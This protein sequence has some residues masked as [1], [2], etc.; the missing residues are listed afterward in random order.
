[1]HLVQGGASGYDD[2]GQRTCRQ[3]A[4]VGYSG[5]THR[6]LDGFYQ[7]GR[8]FIGGEYPECVACLK[9][10]RVLSGHSQRRLLPRHQAA[11]R[12][13]AIRRGHCLD[14]GRRDLRPRKLQSAVL[15]GISGYDPAIEHQEFAEAAQEGHG[16]EDQAR[17]CACHDEQ[18]WILEVAGLPRGSGGAD[19]L[20][21]CAEKES[22][23]QAGDEELPKDAARGRNM[24]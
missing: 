13:S 9:N 10:E 20:T 11:V 23:R 3:P 5:V 15:L 21:H 17:K 22:N 1:M 24:T 4:G 2:G 7:R 6:R 19:E 12:I 18:D 8:I 14:I 16:P